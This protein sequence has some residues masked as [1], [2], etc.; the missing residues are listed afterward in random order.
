MSTRLQDLAQAAALKAYAPYSSFQV[1]CALR[2]AAGGLHQGCNVEN[3]SLGL[4]LCAERTAIASAIAAEGPNL[5]I[6]ELAVCC[7]QAQFSPC[8]ACRQWIAEFAAPECRIHFRQGGQWR[9]MST[10]ELLPSGFGPQSMR[11]L[12][13]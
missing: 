11:D 1:G 6:T 8:G 7:L 10:A 12:A 3:A 2:T 5:R 9:A 4:T 13:G